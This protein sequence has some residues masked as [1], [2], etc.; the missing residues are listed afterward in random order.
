MSD[1]NKNEICEKIINSIGDNILHKLL[2]NKYF[3]KN[4]NE[5]VGY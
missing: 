4:Q 2:S 1:K 3:R 5:K